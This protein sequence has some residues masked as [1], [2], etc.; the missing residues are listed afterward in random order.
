MFLPLISGVTRVANEETFIK[1]KT[2]SW[3]VLVINEER[4]IYN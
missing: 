2:I 1:N 3:E 4:Y